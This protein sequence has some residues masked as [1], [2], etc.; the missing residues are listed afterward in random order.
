[1]FEET[2]TSE[3]TN[4]PSALTVVSVAVGVAVGTFAAIKL[5]KRIKA[6]KAERAAVVQEAVDHLMDTDPVKSNV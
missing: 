2:T 6:R 3:E 4:S 5:T 1:M